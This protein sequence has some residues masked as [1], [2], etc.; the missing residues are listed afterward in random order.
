MRGFEWGQ[1]QNPK[2]AKWPFQSTG[3]QFAA[4]DIATA[5]VLLGALS[6]L[7]GTIL[8]WTV[9]SQRGRIGVTTHSTDPPK[10]Q[11]R[12]HQRHPR[13]NPTHNEP[14]ELNS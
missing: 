2:E 8:S 7:T 14:I 9:L 3:G 4:A 13:E 10:F 5:H 12:W 11:Q 6:L 1:P